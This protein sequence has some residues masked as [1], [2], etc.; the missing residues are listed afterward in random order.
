VTQLSFGLYFRD[1][2]NK[3]TFAYIIPVYE[4]RGSYTETAN[5][6]DTSVS[7][8][9]SPLEYRSR[10][11]TIAPESASLQSKPFTEKKFFE[12]YLTKQNIENAIRDSKQN[13][14]TDISKY[15]L[16]LAGI[17]FELPNH[18]GN[19]HNVS[20]V[21]VSNFTAKIVAEI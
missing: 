12:V 10:Y 7:F 5:A 19:G 18:V 16:T 2:I 20:M 3:I 1:V 11:V 21:N 17:L 8:V 4:S 13:L 9:S 6:H 15:E 14:S